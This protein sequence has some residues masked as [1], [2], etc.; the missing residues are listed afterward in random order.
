VG[1]KVIVVV[2]GTTAHVRL[3]ES[4]VRHSFRHLPFV[5][6]LRGTHE[7][8]TVAWIRFVCTVKLENFE[9]T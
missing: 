5:L 9:R 8:G 2:L 6:G 3:G 7:P 4:V 1:V